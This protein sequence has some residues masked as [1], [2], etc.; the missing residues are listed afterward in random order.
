MAER[1]IRVTYNASADPDTA[2]VPDY[3]IEVETDDYWTYAEVAEFVQKVVFKKQR[4]M[5][6]DSTGTVYPKAREKD[7]V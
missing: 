6:T 2:Q 4:D 7:A 3:T 5:Y 1:Y